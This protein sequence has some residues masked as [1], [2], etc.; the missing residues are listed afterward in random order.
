MVC[1]V[2]I[3]FAVVHLFIQFLSEEKEGCKGRLFE[4]NEGLLSYGNLLSYN[5]ILALEI[6]Q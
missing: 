2:G 5:K 3:L 6:H 1:W 4:I